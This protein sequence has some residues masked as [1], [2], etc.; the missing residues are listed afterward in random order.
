[1]ER[2]PLLQRNVKH[3][4]RWVV[5]RTFAT[6][7][8]ARRLSKDDEHHDLCSES[9]VYLAS[10]ASLL[11]RLGPHARTATRYHISSTAA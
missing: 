3:P 7:G 10:I 6:L 2:F 4:R 1:M 8:R 9:I 5:E 11:R